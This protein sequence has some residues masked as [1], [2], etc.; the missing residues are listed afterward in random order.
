[1]VGD[2]G[3]FVEKLFDSYSIFVLIF[4]GD[5]GAI[6]FLFGD[7]G[8]DIEFII[9]QF[10]VAYLNKIY[11][12]IVLSI[13]ELSCY[14]ACLAYP[15]LLELRL[16][17]HPSIFSPVGLVESFLKKSL[18]SHIFLVRYIMQSFYI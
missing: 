11:W 1:M 14:Y 17:G 5:C 18:Q 16:R 2:G 7:P 6:D 15:A 13:T 9:W 4:L 3:D 12:N 8:F 10:R